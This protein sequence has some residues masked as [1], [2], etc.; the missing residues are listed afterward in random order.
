MKELKIGV[1]VDGV[2]ANQVGIILPRINERFK[3][4]LVYS[5]VTDWKLPIKDTDIAKLILEYQEDDSI[6]IGMETHPGSISIV[7]ELFEKFQVDIVTARAKSTIS[8]TK[9]WLKNNGIKYDEFINTKE[10]GKST[11]DMDILVDDYTG[12]IKE[13]LENT[14]GTAILFDQPWNKGEVRSDLIENCDNERLYIAENWSEVK[15]TI[16]QIVESKK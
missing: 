9:K 2:L 12:N 14:D 13:F 6:I 16:N 1:D 7:N 3:T 5:D 8:A 15:K 10:E 4:N 11:H